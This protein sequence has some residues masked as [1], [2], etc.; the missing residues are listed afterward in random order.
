MRGGALKAELTMSQLKILHATL[1]YLSIPVNTPKHYCLEAKKCLIL[2]A[3][4][5]YEDN[6]AKIATAQRLTQ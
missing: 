4:D 2:N 5:E 1:C 6:V 3:P